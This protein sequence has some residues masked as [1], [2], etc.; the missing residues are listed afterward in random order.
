[1]KENYTRVYLD[2]LNLG[3]EGDPDS[4]PFCGRPATASIY[5]PE[6]RD[7]LYAPK[8]IPRVYMR[9]CKSHY[10]MSKA[11][12]KKS[13]KAPTL[14]D[15][16]KKFHRSVKAGEALLPGWHI[17]KGEDRTAWY[18][19]KHTVPYEDYKALESWFI[20]SGVK[21]YPAPKRRSL[22]EEFAEAHQEV[23]VKSILVFEE[24][25]SEG[26]EESKVT[27]SKLF[28]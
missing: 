5:Y 18:K 13:V 4:C 20:Q 17:A 19:G 9:M 8:E 12:I 2:G 23:N 1:M 24:F 7:N 28:E 16:V 26:P 27:S 10:D 3:P 21:F 22:L 25:L 15:L 14:E 6:V 11:F